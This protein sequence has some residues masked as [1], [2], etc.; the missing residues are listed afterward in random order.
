[1]PLQFLVSVTVILLLVSLV[2]PATGSPSL[3]RR[4]W[5]AHSP[6]AVDAKVDTFIND[7]NE[8][9]EVVEWME[10]RPARAIPPFTSAPTPCRTF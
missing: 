3:R 7:W 4:K 1:M 5:P 9:P 8:L 2:I 6:P 10:L